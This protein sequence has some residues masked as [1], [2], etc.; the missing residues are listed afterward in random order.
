MCHRLPGGHLKLDHSLSTK[1]IVTLREI[2]SEKSSFQ[3]LL[4]HTELMLM[5]AK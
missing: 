1:L 4:L 2:L 3:N 5:L